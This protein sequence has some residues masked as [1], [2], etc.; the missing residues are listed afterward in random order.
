MSDS[1]GCLILLAFIAIGLVI[2][3]FHLVSS[4]PVESAAIFTMATI[5]VIAYAR[6]KK[7]E[8]AKE[9]ERR[10][11]AEHERRTREENEKRERER[12]KKEE[13]KQ[14]VRAGKDV[15]SKC[16]T[17]G[18]RRCSHCSICINCG[19]NRSSRYSDLCDKCGKEVGRRECAIA[20][21]QER[22]VCWDCLSVEPSRC[23]CGNCYNCYGNA[24]GECN[25]CSD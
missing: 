20:E 11:I 14:A 1:T 5:F 25:V 22:D 15:C 8:Q 24:G 13:L 16:E 2:Y 4:F 17:I 7:L 9:T 21:G 18:P 23:Y 3:L 19:W 6:H 10:H 12:R